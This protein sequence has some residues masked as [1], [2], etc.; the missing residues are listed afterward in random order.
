[1]LKSNFISKDDPKLEKQIQ[2]LET[3]IKAEP[4]NLRLVSNLISFLDWHAPK[5]TGQSPYS[6]CQRALHASFTTTDFGT[7]PLSENFLLQ[8]F[9]NWNSILDSFDINRSIPLTQIFQGNRLTINGTPTNC[10]T[11]LEMF[12]NT[13]VIH[14][15]CYDCFKVQ[16]LPLSVYSLIILYFNMMK[17]RLDRNNYRKCMVELRESVKFPY[18]GYVFCESEIEAQLCLSKIRMEMEISG[19]ND[20]CYGISHGC[21][22]Y[23]IKY[24]S[25]KYSPD[26]S[27]RSFQRPENWDFIEKR[28]TSK[29][30]KS[31]R[32][33]DDQSNE[34]LTIKDMLSFETW[35]KYA[36]II[37]D[38]SHK[39]LQT[40]IPLKNTETFSDRVSKQASSRVSDLYELRARLN[41]D[42]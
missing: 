29:K 23:G 35:L 6:E 2:Q 10:A 36:E 37:G 22:E 34:A 16:I 7:A 26:G 42:Q 12:K 20:V 39:K 33:I 41:S 18:K 25:F 24:P 40:E 27:H 15:V 14:N 32:R 38:K 3:R 1:M 4:N 9:P 11:Y 31:G 8:N 13:D 5:N 28:F 17:I 30:L 19:I 21:S